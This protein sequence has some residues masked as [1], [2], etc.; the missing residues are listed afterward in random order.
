MGGMSNS[1]RLKSPWPWLLLAPT[2]CLA[3]TGPNPFAGN[4]QAAAE[5]GKLFLVSC[6]PCHGRGGEGG[7]GQAEGIQAPDLARGVY[8]AGTRDQDLFRVISQGVPSSGMPSFEPLGAARIWRLVTFVRTLSR[9]QNAPAAAA[10]AG[11]ALFW[12]RGNCGRCHRVGN[13][14][15]DLGPDLA[16]WRRL[17]SIERL[18][19][20]IVDPD[21]EITP[22]FELVTIVTRDH[23]TVSGI[24]KYY[25]NFSARLIDSA[26]NEHT[27]LRNDVV[28]M[29]R[30]MR[31]LMPGDYGKIFSAVEIDDLVAYILKLRSEGGLE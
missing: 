24:A 20:A 18:R 5:G 15:I 7:Q 21:A 12:G 1:S 22:G 27:Y 10:A 14:G 19:T 30:E 26:G 28:S 2:L 16:R 29:R 6:A 4:L 13:K 11:A 25:D 23:K 9:R 3:Q 31:S 8:K 17:G